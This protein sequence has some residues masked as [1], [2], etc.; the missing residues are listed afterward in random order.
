MYYDEQHTLLYFTLKMPKIVLMIRCGGKGLPS[1][2]ML[3]F[4]FCKSR[5]LSIIFFVYFIFLYYF[6]NRLRFN[7]IKEIYEI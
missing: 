3:N 4:I 2:F 6:L 1:I 5:Y 7:L